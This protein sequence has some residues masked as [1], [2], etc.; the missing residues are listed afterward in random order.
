MHARKVASRIHKSVQNVQLFVN[1]HKK[2]FEQVRW[3]F[4]IDHLW[5]GLGSIFSRPIDAQHWLPWLDELRKALTCD[6]ANISPKIMQDRFVRL[7]GLSDS[8]VGYRS[9]MN[10]HNYTYCTSLLEAECKSKDLRAAKTIR[11]PMYAV[12]EILH[13]MPNVKVIFYTRDPRGIINSMSKIRGSGTT[14]KNALNLCRCIQEDYRI[15]TRLQRAFP[16]RLI[17]VTY[18]SLAAQPQETAEKIYEFIGHVIPQSVTT[19]LAHNTQAKQKR[20]LNPFSTRRN[21]TAR[22]AAWKTEL[23][24]DDLHVI[25]NI[26][27]N[28]FDKLGYTLWRFYTEHTEKDNAIYIE[29]QKR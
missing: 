15:F 3:P 17:R 18:E 5:R 23:D 28:T 9:C 14:E 8:F 26:C 19:W 11:V 10:E 25:E 21:S 29:N 20:K 6:I 16:E 2:L 4:D 1:T 22:K 13:T 27:K 24:A 7:P 12:E